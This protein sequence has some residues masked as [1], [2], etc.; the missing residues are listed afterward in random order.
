MYKINS[1]TQHGQK[2]SLHWERLGFWH[3][4]LWVWWGIKYVHQPSEVKEALSISIKASL[5]RMSDVLNNLK[6]YFKPKSSQ[7]NWILSGFSHRI[8]EW[9]H[10]Q[11]S[12]AT[13]KLT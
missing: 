13:L 3:H 2:P 7:I 8:Q 1:T 5:V 9:H 6:E 10:R 4:V 11:R 12:V